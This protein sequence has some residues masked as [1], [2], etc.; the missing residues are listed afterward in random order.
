M[1]L[2]KYFVWVLTPNLQ[3]TPVL[4]LYSKLGRKGWG[5]QEGDLWFGFSLSIKRVVVPSRNQ[6]CL[7][8]LRLTEHE[9]LTEVSCDSWNLT[10]PPFQSRLLIPD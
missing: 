7:P 1:Q 4:T 3:I 9:V 6:V 10:S 5:F 2:A 8:S